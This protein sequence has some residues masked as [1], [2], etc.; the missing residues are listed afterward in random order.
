M[1]K[2]DHSLSLTPPSEMSGLQR[3]GALVTGLGILALLT[4]FLSATP[5]SP[6]LT[7]GTACVFLATAGIL[8]TVDRQKYRQF[9]MLCL[10][11]GIIS[12][13]F[14]VLRVNL[15]GWV[16]FFLIFG[17]TAV[18]ALIYFWSSFGKGPAGI[19]NNGVFHSQATRQAGVISWILAILFTG[20]YTCLYWF[21]D[22]LFGLISATDPLCYALTGSHSFW[23]DASGN[24]Q[25]VSPWFTYTFIYTMAVTVMGVRFLLRYRHSNYQIV[26]TLCV[27]FFQ[28]VLAFAL[29]YLFEALNHKQA[30][31]FQPYVKRYVPVY[32]DYEKAKTTYFTLKDSVDLM[33]SSGDL[34]ALELQLMET[35]YLAMQHA[36]K[37]YY[38]ENVAPYRPQF[39]QHYFTYFWPLGYSSLQPGTLEDYLGETPWDGVQVPHDRQGEADRYRL[40]TKA[41]LGTFGW[42]A[43]GFSVFMSFIGVVILTYFFGKR[44]YCSFVCGCGGLA[45]TAGDAFRH[46]SDKSLRAWQIERWSIHSVL[47]LITLITCLL[48]VDWKLHFLGDGLKNNLTSGYGFL[49]G[50]VFAGAIGTGF[51]PILG[52]RIWCRFGCPQA[53]ILGL[54]Q[55][56]FSRF[57]ITTNGGQCISCGNCSTYCEM[58]IDVKA[59][60]QRG[61][62]IVRASC[63]GCGVCSSVCPRGVLNLENGPLDTRFNGLEPIS[64]SAEE[65]KVNDR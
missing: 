44:W 52:S 5:V 50:S 55:R 16:M 46:Q 14:L 7:M 53:A 21:P 27:T 20:F 1:S 47:V 26:R 39:K 25:D 59:Y 62:N 9:I 15:P 42:V 43:V 30:D 23:I 2:V 33:G 45:E 51:Y 28:L 56:Y 40:E 60:A 6:W 12:L 64:V 37:R 61:E 48:L 29:P 65:I 3:F 32:R 22:Q 38:E 24:V 11:V 34:G 49:I 63:V 58:G 13:V 36:A 41:G 57:R 31:S 8:S 10:A 35:K 19:K 17:L 4:G 54:L 18:G